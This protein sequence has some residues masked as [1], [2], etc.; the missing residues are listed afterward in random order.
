MHRI[1]RRVERQAGWSLGR[2]S[3][4]RGKT[5]QTKT[6]RGTTSHQERQM[7]EI[8]PTY[9]IGIKMKLELPVIKEILK[10]ICNFFL[11]H[12][13]G[14]F[15]FTGDEV[16]STPQHQFQENKMDFKTRQPSKEK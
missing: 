6:H 1:L 7:E 14:S 16:M 13:I 10:Y 8:Q 9:V 5:H 15:K 3:E 11:I 4:K 12:L 2:G